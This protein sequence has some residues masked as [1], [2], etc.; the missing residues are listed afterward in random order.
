MLT[1]FGYIKLNS[2]VI[3]R[4]LI[5]LAALGWGDTSIH[6]VYLILLQLNILEAVLLDGYKKNYLNAC[7]GLLVLISSFYL[8]LGWTG[9]YITIDNKSYIFWIL[10]YTVWNAN[11]VSLQLSGGYY[12]HH[13]L[14]LLSPIAAC[15]VLSD[16]SI[17]LML[18][19]TSLL[20]GIATLASVKKRL[21]GL[22]QQKIFVDFFE[23]AQTFIR[24]PKTQFVLLSV[25]GI[26]ILIQ[27][28]K[29]N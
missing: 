26:C 6:W 16:F 14:I 27:W 11:F 22:E 3:G 19:E 25:V 28:I 17:W 7:S 23:K 8:M 10:A 2:L 13:F 5:I 18:R 1:R 4:V 15:L 24:N 12:L 20:L 9:S 29:V 21:Q